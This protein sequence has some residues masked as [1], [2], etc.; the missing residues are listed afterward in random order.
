MVTYQRFLLPALT[1]VVL[2]Q[3]AKL[4]ILA[5]REQL[6]ITII[7]G[8]LRIVY[9][10]NTGLAFGMFT[11]NNLLLAAISSIVALIIIKLKD[12]FKPGL[13]VIAAQLILGGTVGNLLDRL[14]NGAVIDFTSVLTFPVFNI[15]DASLTIGAVLIV[16]SY[17]KEKYEKIKPSS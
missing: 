4:L 3:L 9:A 10:T 16:Y 2:D 7:P 5:S 6:P 13:E 17:L 15:A 11:G 14:W 1:I 8:F 12:Q